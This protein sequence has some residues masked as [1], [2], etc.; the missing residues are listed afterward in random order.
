MQDKYTGDIGDFG[1]Y[2]LLK[3]LVKLSNNSIN[4]GVNWYLFNQPEKKSGDGKFIDYLDSDT[5][6]FKYY[7]KC[8][9]ILFN[10]LYNITKGNKRRVS[11]IEKNSIL[12]YRT[13]FYS[14]P[15]PYFPNNPLRQIQAREEWFINSF[16]LLSDV[17]FVFLDPDNGINPPNT[18]KSKPNA[19]KYV[20]INEIE[21]YYSTQKSV[22]VYQH[23]DHQSK[24]SR[25]EKYSIIA[26]KTCSVNHI[27]VLRYKKK[28]VRDYLLLPQERHLLLIGKLVNFLTASPYNFLFE[29]Y[30]LG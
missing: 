2:I 17:D 20:F 4:L 27:K 3:E 18:E 25:D 28:S 13:R 7:E 11:E 8:D 26:K 16:G 12:P 6:D 24:L 19:A 10:Q 29:E 22:L 23:W 21:K 1:K 14:E 9:S 5:K 30:I 15:I